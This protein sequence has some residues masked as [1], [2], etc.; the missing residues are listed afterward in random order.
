MLEIRKVVC[1]TCGSKVVELDILDFEVG[2]TTVTLF[3]AGKCDHCDKY[4]QWHEK[5]TCTGHSNLKE[6]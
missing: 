3:K 4:Y 1:P 2:N 5:Y 6:I